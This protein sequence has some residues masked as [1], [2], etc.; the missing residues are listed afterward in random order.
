MVN[1]DPADIIRQIDEAIQPGP[2]A[3]TWTPQA[4]PE[5][6][7]WAC[8]DPGTMLAVLLGTDG[9]EV[10]EIDRHEPGD[11]IAKLVGDPLVDRMSHLTGLDF[12]VGDSSQGNCSFNQCAS[13]FLLKLLRDAVSGDYAVNDD[14]RDHIKKLLDSKQWAPV[15]HG[16]C[17][18]TGVDQSRPGPLPETFR[19]WF[20]KLVSAVSERQAELVRTVLDQLGISADRVEEITIFTL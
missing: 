16:P 18:I 12:W 9:T 1:D 4:G 5:G 11:D 3:A 2:D 20:D 6:S 19:R 15:V 13:A 8:S 14:D 10:V 7:G 17:L